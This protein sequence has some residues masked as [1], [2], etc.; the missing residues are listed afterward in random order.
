MKDNQERTEEGGEELV[1]E[2][3]RSQR[4]QRLGRR[5]RYRYHQLRS[6]IALLTAWSLAALICIWVA[7]GPSLE[8]TREDI[9]RNYQEAPSVSRPAKAP[10][11]RSK[12]EPGAQANFGQMPPET[13]LPEG[14]GPAPSLLPYLVYGPPVI[15]ILD[16][17][18][19]RIQRGG[20]TPP[21]SV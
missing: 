10:N 9:N 12:S 4:R 19:R 8:G 1:R 20:G 18:R 11:A 14:F 5:H 17:L 13:P 2:R 6:T 3:I 7:Q 21:R 15:V 16:M